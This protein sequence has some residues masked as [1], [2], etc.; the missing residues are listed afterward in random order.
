MSAMNATV[1]AMLAEGLIT[2]AQAEKFLAT[3]VCQG[4]SEDYGFGSW[5]R[6]FWKRKNEDDKFGCQVRVFQDVLTA[7]SIAKKEGA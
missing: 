3:H 2:G 6:R 4:V 5:I 1:E 7:A